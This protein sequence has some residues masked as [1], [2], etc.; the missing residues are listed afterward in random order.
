MKLTKDV[1]NFNFEKYTDITQ[2]GRFYSLT[3]NEKTTR[4]YTSV[5]FLV[6][7]NKIF[8]NKYLPGFSN[9]YG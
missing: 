1:G 7:S 2:L 3:I 5:N 8:M 6:K 9:E 4:L